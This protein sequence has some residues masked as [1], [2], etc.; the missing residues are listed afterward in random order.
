MSTGGLV[1][2]VSLMTLHIVYTSPG[3]SDVSTCIDADLIIQSGF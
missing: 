2:D 3:R 1:E